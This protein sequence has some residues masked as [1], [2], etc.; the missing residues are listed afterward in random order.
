MTTEEL[1]ALYATTA[2]ELWAAIG[3]KSNRFY[4][5]E[6]RI[7]R[8]L[9]ERGIEAQRQLLPLLESENS[10]V[11]LEAACAALAF[12]SELAVP[13]LEDLAFV[14]WGLIRFNAGMT[15]KCWRE[16]KPLDI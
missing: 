7:R 9:R 5:V 10:Y 1:V 8:E 3:T 4:H 2:D 15:L 6:K 16:G 11:R 12:A 13:V 14:E